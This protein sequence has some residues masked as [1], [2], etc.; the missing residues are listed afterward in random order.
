MAMEHIHIERDGPVGTLVIDRPDRF[1]SM[2]VETA[3]DFRKA[4]LQLA[5]AADVRCVIVRGTNGI[6]CSGADLKYIRAQGSPQ[7][8]GYLRPDGTAAPPG[9]GDSFKEILEYIHSTI[10]EIKRAPKPFIAAVD[11]V[12]AAGGFGIA[13]ACDLVF[14]SDRATFE[15]AY[16]KT[17][18]TGAE[19]STFFLPRLIGLRMA[20]G[21]VLLNPRL[22]A[23]E[24]KDLR[25]I[26]DVF[27][28][29]Q[30]D[31][32]VMAIAQ[33]I[34]AGPTKAYAVAKSLIN[35]AAGVDQ[36]DYHLDEELQHLVRSA[37]GPDF[38]DGLNAFFDKRAAVF[39]GEG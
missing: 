37:D 19:S 27:P 21:L 4:G 24:A 16:H 15:W 33:R 34:A 20:M 3:R 13:M 32:D 35:Q 9:F 2:D 39:E 18:L 7:D 1:N 5:R 38:S 26:N 10:S 14:A 29:Q 31:A 11:G 25:L 23:A 17:G 30:F 36:L 12:A 8:F 28:R 22:G 6:F